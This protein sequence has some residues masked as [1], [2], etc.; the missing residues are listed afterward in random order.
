MHEHEIHTD[1][2][3]VRRLL[4]DRFPAWAE[5]PIERV[6]SSGTDHALYRLGDGL[7]VRL[8]RVDWAAGQA[9]LEGRWLPILGPHLPLDVPV[10]LGVGDPAE[11]YPWPWSV[12]PWLEGEDLTAS[13]DLD[14]ERLASDL[15]GFVRALRAIDATGAPA[16]V[17]DLDRGVPLGNRDAATREALARLRDDLD[18]GAVAAAW[19]AALAA[20]PWDRPPTWIHGDLQGG[21]LLARDGRLRAVI[22]F[23]CL[24]AGDPACDLLGAWQLFD[25]AGRE[26]FR[27]AVDV[28]DAT[29]ARGRGWALSVALIYLPYYR[30]SNPAG[31]AI[32]RGVIDEV[33]A[34]H[35]TGAAE[36]P[37]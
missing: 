31:I 5:L 36:R 34:D 17:D 14:P 35:A 21:N 10:P 9:T 6:A 37:G 19:E 25:A 33:L 4:R 22:D 23:G 27:E 2:D 7:A 29:W 32:A 13:P 24:G 16:P 12:V 15:G 18:V 8:P 3:L 28:D 1:A 11:G 30:H 26:R 20:P